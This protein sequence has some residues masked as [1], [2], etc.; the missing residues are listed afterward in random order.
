MP[1]DSPIPLQTG[2]PPPEPEAR[3]P[4]D[5]QTAREFLTKRPAG[6]MAAIMELA[7][8]QQEV[9][10]QFLPSTPADRV[11]LDAGT[12]SFQGYDVPLTRDSV[13]AIKMILAME[14]CRILELERD[15][16]FATV[17][18]PDLQAGSGDGGTDVPA[19][20]GEATALE[21]EAASG[22][23]EVQ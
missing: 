12:A 15:R 9:M 3:M 4:A 6:E 23:G 17:Q 1:M 10:K 7:E 14:V 20:S 18:Q 5:R 22:T 8:R 11:N 13:E 2:T 19:V 16:I 21:P